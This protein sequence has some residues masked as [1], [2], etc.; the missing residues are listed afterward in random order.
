MYLTIFFIIIL[1]SCCWGLSGSVRRFRGP[2]QEG[3]E[4]RIQGKKGLRWQWG[5]AA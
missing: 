1:R 3:A 5:D 4:G 2:V